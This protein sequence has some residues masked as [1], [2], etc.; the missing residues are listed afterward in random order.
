MLDTCEFYFHRKFQ[1]GDIILKADGIKFFMRSAASYRYVLV[2]IAIEIVIEVVLPN[3]N[4][5][6][7]NVQVSI[8]IDLNNKTVITLL[9]VFFVMDAMGRCKD[10]LWRDQCSATQ[11]IYPLRHRIFIPK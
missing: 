10:M 1:Y 4:W 2:F 9:Q 8:I 3:S 7:A 11:I 5:I 6:S